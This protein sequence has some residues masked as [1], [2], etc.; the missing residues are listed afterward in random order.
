[1]CLVAL[2]LMLPTGG[3]RSEIKD[4]E[5]VV[6]YP[7]YARQVDDARAWNLFVRGSIFEPEEDSTRREALLGLLQRLAG[8]DRE[9][10]AARLFER[11]ARGFL[12][13]NEGGKEI[14]IRL[15]GEA[16]AVGTSE[17]NGHF[18]ATL[19]L[20]AAEVER[21]R[22]A[23]PNSADWLT[24][25]AVTRPGDSRTFAGRVRLIGPRGLSVISDIDDTIKVSMVR[26]R[27]AL[28]RNTFL[29][30]LKPVE[31]TAERYAR[32]AA[33]AA[34]FHY[35]SASPWQLYEPLAEFVAAHGFPAGAFHLKRFRLKDQSALALLGSQER[36][37]SARIERILA[38]FPGRRFI[39]V[40]DSGEQD[41][42]IY[43]AAVR[44]HPEQIVRIFIRD[45]DGPERDDARFQAAFDGV[46]AAR[47][48]VFSHP[49]ELPAIL[50]KSGAGPPD[51][52]ED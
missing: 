2:A 48:R 12:V 35:L 49:E 9:E 38:D 15:G 22:R 7:T 42:E 36:Y 13:D 47:W 44:K 19:K 50:P 52:S 28:V 8:L 1:M 41:P 4:D 3:V 23:D 20:P 30:E 18:S 29:R 6:F 21:L 43:G 10:A 5:R 46:S 33:A 34:V 31:G 51:V 24:F 37:K 25:Q 40:G 27:R 32:W 14:A 39:L 26:D 16:Y 11:R 17:S 45:V